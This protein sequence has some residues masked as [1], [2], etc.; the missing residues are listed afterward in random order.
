[1]H[2]PN[3]QSVLHLKNIIWPLIKKQL[4]KAEVHIYGAYPSQK[5]LQLNNKK[6]AFL[7]KGRAENVASVMEKAKVCL[8]PLLF[9]AGLKGKLT[10]HRK[11]L[12]QTEEKVEKWIRDALLM[13][14]NIDI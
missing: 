11:L 13:D 8:A 14:M 4:P 9:G 2:E 10:V 7:V 12:K 5:V 1:M 6:D 3:W